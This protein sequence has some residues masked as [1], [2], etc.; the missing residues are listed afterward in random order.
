MAQSAKSYMEKERPKFRFMD[1]E[2]WQDAIEIAGR[3]FDVADRLDSKRLY[4]FAEQLR[5]SGLSMSN[6]PVK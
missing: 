1:L 4:K 6:N 5:S 3:L 2:I